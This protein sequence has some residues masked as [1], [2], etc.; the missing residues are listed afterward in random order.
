MSSQ[1]ISEIS[2]IIEFPNQGKPWWAAGDDGFLP[3]T[4]LLEN[5]RKFRTEIAAKRVLKKYSEWGYDGFVKPLIKTQ[6]G[7]GE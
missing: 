3:R 6:K 2:Y 5:A 1:L 7:G 4:I